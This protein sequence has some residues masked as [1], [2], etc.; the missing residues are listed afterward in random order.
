L[1]TL[2]R[3]G[4]GLFLCSFKTLTQHIG[5]LIQFLKGYDERRLKPWRVSLDHVP[6][7]GPSW[8]THPSLGR[9]RVSSP[10]GK[11]FGIP[12]HCPEFCYRNWMEI[13]LSIDALARSDVVWF[14]QPTSRTL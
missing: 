4:S 5:R 13:L 7:G 1:V 9:V 8:G 11:R 12:E 10:R 2:G 14:R 3:F 6:S